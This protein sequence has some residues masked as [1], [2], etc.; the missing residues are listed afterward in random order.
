MASQ[1]EGPPRSSAVLVISMAAAAD[2]NIVDLAYRLQNLYDAG[3][4]DYVK[5]RRD[6]ATAR[7]AACA[8]QRVARA[9]VDLSMAKYIRLD[10]IAER[11]VSVAR[12]DWCDDAEGK[13]TWFCAA[14]QAINA[15][16]AISPAP[17]RVSILDILLG[18]QAGLFGT[19][20][21][22]R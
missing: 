7:S 1:A 4:G 15:I 18:H 22:M 8:L 14:E 3:L 16:L 9:R 20:A 12:G 2:P 19:D 17:E 21:Q 13:D 10:L 5:E 6:W 11:L